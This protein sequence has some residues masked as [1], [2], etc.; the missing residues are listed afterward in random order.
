MHADRSENL[1]HSSNP[2]IGYL[3]LFAD[4][5]WGYGVLLMS[6][7]YSA[8]LVA[9]GADDN[10]SVRGIGSLFKAVVRSN[11]RN[12]HLPGRSSPHI[13]RNATSPYNRIK[14][15]CSI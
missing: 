9:F 1:Y 3:E 2:L 5:V 7:T 11:H 14:Q 13:I 8:I 15:L 6:P 10:I 12:Q 4:E